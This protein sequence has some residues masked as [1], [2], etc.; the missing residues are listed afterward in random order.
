[1][2]VIG[3]GTVGLNAMKMAIGL[4]A[5]VETLYSNTFHIF[6]AVKRVDLVI[7]AVLIPGA[8][9]SKLVT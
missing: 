9:A 3:A 1:M 8:S 4:G 2:V 7:G 6:E 5:Q